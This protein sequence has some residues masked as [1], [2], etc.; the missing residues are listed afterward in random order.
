LK[1]L[2]EEFFEDRDRVARFEREAKALA[3]LNAGQ[4][5]YVQAF[6]SL[7]GRWQVSR[8]G[9][10]APRW[11]RD[12]RELFYVSGDQM[13]AAPIQ[14]EPTFSP[15]EPRPLFRIEHPGS[16]EWSDIYDVAPDGKRFV[17]LVRQKDSTKAPR[18][19]VILN[20]GKRLAEGAR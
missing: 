12:G 1:V 8:G 14:Q 3:A 17:V 2:P 6:P 7:A 9:G 11:S 20:F 10:S 16:S 15:G 5:I 4:Q 13:F 18:I 19:D